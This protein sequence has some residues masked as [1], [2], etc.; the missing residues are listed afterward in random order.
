[1]PRGKENSGGV[2]RT[3]FGHEYAKH[4]LIANGGYAAKSGNYKEEGSTL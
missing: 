1:M 3:N 2:T 4:R